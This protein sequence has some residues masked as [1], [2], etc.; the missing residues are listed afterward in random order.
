MGSEPIFEDDC[1]RQ[2]IDG[3]FFSSEP[4]LGCKPLACFNAGQTLVRVIDRE[5][6]MR[7]QLIAEFA[8]GTRSRT[9]AAIHV[10]RETHDELSDSSSIDRACNLSEI[11]P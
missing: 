10:E 9:L 2:R 1:R 7:S 5:I 8:R 6:Q 4:A 3:A 11:L